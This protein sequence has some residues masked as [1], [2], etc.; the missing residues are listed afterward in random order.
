VEPP[1][2]D[3]AELHRLIR[4]ENPRCFA[5]LAMRFGCDIDVLRYL[6]EC[7]PAPRYQSDEA[8]LESVLARAARALPR[9]GFI[10]LYLTQQLSLAA[11][12]ERI[13]LSRQAVTRLAHRYGVP[14]RRPGR[15]GRKSDHR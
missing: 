1:N 15:A 5:D 9:D 3:T 11:V 10:E 8:R 6:L 4:V 14:V 12:A 13:G 2:F 7:T